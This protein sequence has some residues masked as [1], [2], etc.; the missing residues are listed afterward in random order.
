MV[1]VKMTGKMVFFWV[2]WNA[3]EEVHKPTWE[4][5]G[6]LLIIIML[7]KPTNIYCIF[8]MCQA[9]DMHFTNITFL[10]LKK[11]YEEGKTSFCQ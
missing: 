7:P 11:L 6:G 8:T 3:K 9:L 10:I 1:S 5:R 2:M 4:L